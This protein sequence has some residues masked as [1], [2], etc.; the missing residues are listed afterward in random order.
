MDCKTK[1]A[2][3]YKKK[4][5]YI[6]THT[7][8]NE[9]TFQSKE[10]KDMVHSN[11]FSIPKTSNDFLLLDAESALDNLLKDEHKCNSCS[12]KTFKQL[13]TYLLAI[14]VEKT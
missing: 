1:S 9:T 8:E 6:Y 11:L 10:G 4:K 5:I 3:I 2:S 12:Q 14:S 7:S 13:P